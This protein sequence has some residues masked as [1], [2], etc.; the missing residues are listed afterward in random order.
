MREE[1][2]EGLRAIYGSSKEANELFDQARAAAKETKLDTADVV[3]IYNTEAAS[4]FSAKQLDPIFWNV[5]DV[6]SA[7]GNQK[8][9]QYLRGLGKLNAQDNAMFGTFQQAAMA[10]PGLKNAEEA[11]ADKLGITDKKNLDEK[12]RH[13]FRGRQVKGSVALDAITGAT[14][15]LYDKNGK[16]GDYAKAQGDKSW[17]GILSNIKNGMGDILNMKLPE[18]HAI[19]SFKKILAKIG[20]SSTG[21]FSGQKSAVGKR[22]EKLI[23]NFVDDI[24]MPFGGKML[25]GTDNVLARIL[26]A[27]EQLEKQFKRIMQD[28]TKGVDNFFGSAKGSIMGL[29]GDIGFAIANGM[30]RAAQETILPGGIAHPVDSW[31]NLVDSDEWAK[32]ENWNNN[33]GDAYRYFAGEDKPKQSLAGGG[34]VQGDYFGQPVMI[35]AHAGEMVS[36]LDGQ[37]LPRGRG[38]LDGMQ[39]SSGGGSGG[40]GVSIGNITVP[41]AVT[42]HG[43]TAAEVIQE[44]SVSLSGVLLSEL[45]SALRMQ[46][47]TGGLG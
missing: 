43:A 42:S 10:G 23:A 4:G 3:K 19:N 44:A 39:F 38:S 17:S 37:F 5:A 36:G 33:L 18:N 28:V 29:A 12:L 2:V 13:M 9:Q 30:K 7:R 32:P 45:N 24:F 11:L 8:G 1:S 46:Q 27:G 6:T 35:E 31:K 20:D 47:A 21:L 41:L 40:G 16:A 25:G 22:F 15:S 14:T 34:R 26:D